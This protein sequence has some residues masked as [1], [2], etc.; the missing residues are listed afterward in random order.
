MWP[1]KWGRLWAGCV[2]GSARSRLWLCALRGCLSWFWFLCCHAC[3]VSVCVVLECL[4]GWFWCS[5]G[6][7]LMS[8]SLPS[9]WLKFSLGSCMY[10]MPLGSRGRLLLV[11]RLSS[12]GVFGTHGRTGKDEQR[13]HLALGCPLGFS[14]R[15]SRACSR[16]AM[17]GAGAH[18]QPRSRC[19][20][21][22][23]SMTATSSLI[24]TRI[25]ACQSA[26][27]ASRCR[28]LPCS[29]RA[30]S[31]SRVHTYCRL[32]LLQ[33]RLPKESEQ[34]LGLSLDSS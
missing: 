7:C 25:R 27:G 8:L 11:C 22:W 19:C 4:I 1:Q 31:R 16:F 5:I 13:R 29:D 20:V 34:T 28:T 2:G 33:I 32:C 14:V 12:V 6:P 18:P 10:S 26:A 23:H 17:G 21:I 9:T 15:S 3:I 30:L 24:L